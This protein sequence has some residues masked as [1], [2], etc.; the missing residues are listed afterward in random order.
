MKTLQS[1]LTEPSV[2]PRVVADCV[3]VV[4]EEVH[5]KSGLSGF[6]IKGAYAVVNK[7]KPGFVA[8]AMN[9]L[10]PDFAARLDPFFQAARGAAEPLGAHMQARASQVADALLGITDDRATRAKNASVKK[11]Y[12]KLR[13]TGKKHVET[14]VPRVSAVIEQYSKDAG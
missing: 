9:D 12:E 13:P 6:A 7:V 1:I 10:L 11:A 3:R 8:E 2:R 5:A 14:A 4:D